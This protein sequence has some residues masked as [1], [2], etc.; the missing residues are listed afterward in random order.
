MFEF[1]CDLTTQH[2]DRPAMTLVSP[3]EAGSAFPSQLATNAS[4]YLCCYH[5]DRM[6][7]TTEL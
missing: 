3:S 1:R 4:V 5:G 6:T 2:N 7:A